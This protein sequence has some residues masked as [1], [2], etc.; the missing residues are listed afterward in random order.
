MLASLQLR[1]VGP[2]Q[3]F[4]IE[5]SDR[6]NV[7][8]G[9]NGLGKSFLLDIAFWALTGCWPGDRMAMPAPAGGSRIAEPQAQLLLDRLRAS[10][11]L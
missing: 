2:A 11:R 9:D 1:D 3:S 4:D 5:L 6:L 7:F 10:E 8:T